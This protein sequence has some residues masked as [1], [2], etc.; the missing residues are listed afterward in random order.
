MNDQ[1]EKMKFGFDQEL[2]ELKS[3]FMQKERQYEEVIAKN[4]LE[5]QQMEEELKVQQEE[6]KDQFS[7]KEGQETTK[8]KEEFRKKGEIVEMIEKRQLGYLEKLERIEEE[9]NYQDLKKII[10]DMKDL[11]RKKSSLLDFS[12]IEKEGVSFLE[13]TFIE[14]NDMEVLRRELEHEGKEA[15]ENLQATMTQKKL[16]LFTSQNDQFKEKLKQLEQKN[17]FLKKE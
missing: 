14:K 6:L 16:E 10:E 5:M 4:Q 13:G 2:K 15:M 3:Q 8:L 12:I 11:N 17:N 9:K 1:I 7:A